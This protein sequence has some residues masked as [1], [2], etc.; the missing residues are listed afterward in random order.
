M[1]HLATGPIPV[2]DFGTVTNVD[3]DAGMESLVVEFNA[4]ALNVINNQ[5]GSLHENSALVSFDGYSYSTAIV[6]TTIV[7]P[8]VS[9]TK[10]ASTTPADAGDIVVYDL[11]ISNSN[12]TNV[13]GAYDLQITDTL[14]SFLTFTGASIV[15][16][17]YATELNNTVGNAVDFS[18]DRLD[19]G[20]SANLTIT[21]TVNANVTAGYTLPNDGFVN[22]TSLPGNGTDPNPTGSSTPGG[23]GEETVNGMAAESQTIILLPT[24][25]TSTSLCRPFP[26]L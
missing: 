22:Y 5:L 18:I 7:E 15:V 23:S 4:L 16:P 3:R 13:S 1:G 8:L 12:A 6:E 9:I 20:D 17:G 11:Q 25:T 21:A 26:K 19:P 24:I 10:S 14:D 2:F